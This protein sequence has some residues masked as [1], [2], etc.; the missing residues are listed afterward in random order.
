[1]LTPYQE[2]YR[3]Q[4]IASGLSEAD[5]MKVAARTVTPP[6]QGASKG[7]KPAPA[8]APQAQAMPST[9]PE[10]AKAAPEAASPPPTH[11]SEAAAPLEQPPA[12]TPAQ[13]AAVAPAPAPSNPRTA[14]DLAKIAQ[15]DQ[16]SLFEIAPWADD[17]RGMPNDLARTAIFS[18]RNHKTP[19]ENFMRKPLFSLQ[20]DVVLT[21]TG[22]EL[23][24]KDDEKVFNQLCELAK[25]HSAG[26]EFEF[27]L[28][29]FLRE[30]KWPQNSDYYERLTNSLIRLQSFTIQL[31]TPRLG[32]KLV[33]VALA[34]RLT[35]HE[36]ENKRR[37]YG[38]ISM[39]REILVLFAGQ[40][41]ARQD[42]NA[43]L[44]LKP[45]SRRLMDYAFS[46]RAPNP[47]P[48][49]QFAQMA[50]LSGYTNTRLRQLCKEMCDELREKGLVDSAWL[51]E[52]DSIRVIRK[53]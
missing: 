8:P 40:H 38:T 21:V 45:T 13:S 52:N 5:A 22:Q 16:L 41:Y 50:F 25:H 31:E 53:S 42:W 51:D 6:G 28:G 1:M 46:H 18:A 7:A 49:R 15:G 23:R 11:K 39:P 47:L 14:Q 4:L 44:E 34:G 35:I 2:R 32:G 17:Q 20:K 9:A 30:L 26:Q 27:H 43:I 3:K 29:A 33:S 24:V 12:A 10:P 19:R 37:T 48:M 36:R